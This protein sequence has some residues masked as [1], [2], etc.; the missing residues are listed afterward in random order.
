MLQ[1]IIIC[2]MHHPRILPMINL[3]ILFFWIIM[4]LANRTVIEL[5][6]TR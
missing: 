6:M 1:E 4:L 3:V 2:C 5:P